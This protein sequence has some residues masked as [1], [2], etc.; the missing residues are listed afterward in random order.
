ML[1]DFIYMLSVHSIHIPNIGVQK[2]P[3]ILDKAMSGDKP[4]LLVLA[5]TTN[6]R[7]IMKFPTYQ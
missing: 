1:F 6:R 2:I 4:N 7:W 3:I 5:V